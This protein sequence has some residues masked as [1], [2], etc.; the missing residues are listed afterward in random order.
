MTRKRNTTERITLQAKTLVS[1]Q[2]QLRLSRA[3]NRALFNVAA[4]AEFLIDAGMPRGAHYLLSALQTIE[5]EFDEQM[6]LVPMPG[7]SAD[8]KEG[9]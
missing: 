9:A 1:T 3:A 8:D 7:Q 5:S 4:A 6:K 2:Y